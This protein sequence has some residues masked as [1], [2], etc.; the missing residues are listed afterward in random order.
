M[1]LYLTHIPV[2][3]VEDRGHVYSQPFMTTPQAPPAVKHRLEGSTRS[4]DI[5]RVLSPGDVVLVGQHSAFNQPPAILASRMIGVVGTPK[6]IEE[7]LKQREK[8]TEPRRIDHFNDTLISQWKLGKVEEKTIKGADDK[9]VQMF[10]VYPPDFDPAKK[11]PLVQMVH[12]G[13][14]NAMGNDWSFRWNPQLWAAQG[15]VIAIVNFHGSSGFGQQFTDSIT[16]DYGTKP[17]TDI[18]K[19]TDW[20]EKQPWCDKDRMAAAGGSYGGYMVAYMNGHTDRFKAYV[21]HAGV[22]NYAGQMASDLVVG[23]RRSLGGFPWDDYGRSDKQSANR[24][25]QHFKTPTLVIHGEKDYRVPITQGLEYYNTLKM[26]GVP[27]RLLYFPDENHWVLK[28]Q[29]SRLW[30]QEVFG[31]I[32]KYIGN[33]ATGK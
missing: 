27:A 23:R 32:G 33:G 28:P 21:C 29:N 24:Y 19:A 12:G 7:Q 17:L 31:W 30:H 6:E 9:D 4:L 16:G 2:C 5:S 18:L 3:E 15:W 11:W 1:P 10:L 8:E 13:P 14:H 22:Y 25:A 20:L 26:K